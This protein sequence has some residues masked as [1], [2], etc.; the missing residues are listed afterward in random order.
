MSI[1][2][3]L[4]R[5]ITAVLMFGIQ[6]LPEAVSGPFQYNFMQR[7]LVTALIVGTMCGVLSCYVVLKR[8]ALL[9]D[10]ISHAVLPGVAIAYLL[11][12]PL[13]F[14]AFVSGSVTSIGIGFLQRNSR[15][16]EDSAMGIL[17]TAAFALGIVLISR[18]ATSTHL[19][20]ILFGN[21]LGVN[22]QQAAGTLAAG[23]LALACVAVFYKPLLLYCF[24]PVHASAIGMPTATIH[25]GL[26]LLLTLTIV[27]S[28]E[29]VGVILVVAMLIIPGAAASMLT[30]RLPVM[31]ALAALIGAGSSAAGIYFSFI[32]NVASGGSIVLVAFLVFAIIAVLAPEGPLRG[33]RLHH[34]G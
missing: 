21:V 14:G 32:L 19:M 27:T 15:I 12:I 2:E 34:P 24:D 28:L 6:L 8:W 1:F 16:K 23:L 31:M 10:A 25:Y 22:L 7:A 29:T 9:G 5:A 26:M 11:G 13:F 18:I 20:H 17:F 4:V 33:R 3:N 30:H